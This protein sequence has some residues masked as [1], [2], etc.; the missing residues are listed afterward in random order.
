MAGINDFTYGVLTQGQDRDK[1][2]TF[3]PVINSYRKKVLTDARNKV[4]S[5]MDQEEE[6]TAR[7]AT[8]KAVFYYVSNGDI[9]KISE[10]IEARYVGN[11][12]F[13]DISEIASLQ[14]LSLAISAVTLY[15]R[16]AV[17]GGLP[18]QIAYNLSDAYIHT[19]LEIKD[20]ETITD[21]IYTI[22]YDF[23]Y[24]VYRYKYRDCSALVRKCCEY[25]SRHLHDEISLK[26]LGEITGKSPNYISDSFYR[27]M[28]IRPTLYIRRLK[29]DYARSVIEAADLSVS[30]ISDLLAFP[31]SSSFITYFREA[32]GMTPLQYRRAKERI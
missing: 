25:I 30:A 32:Y 11:T 27:E 22:M 18:E 17:D 28:G 29:L 26:T 24:E 10:M 2:C 19:L 12:K 15:T 31:S 9:V 6:N 13:G 1:F 21:M 7:R 20:A 8:E 14:A 3:S 5:D 4:F 16:A 23:T